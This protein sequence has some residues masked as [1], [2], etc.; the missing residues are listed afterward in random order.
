MRLRTQLLLLA[1]ATLVLP[2]AGWQIVRGLEERL[3]DG[4]AESLHDSARVL[5][6]ALAAT[7]EDAPP[8]GP[9]WFVHAADAPI[10]LDGHADEWRVD[11]A[12]AQAF[13]AGEAPPLQVVMSRSGGALHLLARMRDDSPVRRDATG[14]AAGDGDALRLLIDDGTRIHALRL[15]S[16]TD[17][18][19]L[20]APESGSDVAP[21][22]LQAA[23]RTFAGGWQLEL[24]FAPGFTPRRLGLQ[25]LDVDR[26]GATLR[27]GSEP[28]R[29]GGLWPLVQSSEPL[30]R[31]LQ[32]IVPQGMRARLLHPDGWVLAQAGALSPPQPPERGVWQRSLRA[33]LPTPDAQPAA[34][35]DDVRVPPSM[36]A[37]AAAGDDGTAV[38]ARTPPPWQHADGTLQLRLTALAPLPGSGPPPL[39]LAL[40]RRS[41]AALVAQQALAGLLGWTLLAMVLVAAVLFAYASWLGHR[42]RR[43][44]RAV[45][46]AMARDRNAP[47]AFVASAA[48][49]ELGD[50]SRRFARLLE[51][52]GGYAEYLRT[53]ASKLSH[54]LHTPLAVVR[55]SLENLESQAL[56]ETARPYLLR[57]RD[58]SQRLAAIIR[59]MSEA[60]RV[61]RAIA[62]AEP[63]HVDIA[64]VVGGCAEG[65]RE[66][67]SPRR[68]DVS[69]P[70]Q[71]VWMQAA[72]E[73]LAQALDKLV[74][75][76]AGFCPPHG[77][78][79][80]A[81]SARPD[82]AELVVANSGAPLPAG[83]PARLFESLV[84]VR[85]AG[86][87]GDGTP[88][89]GLG[90]HIVRLIVELHRG[91][92]H[93]HDLPDG[94]GV[95]FR[96]A[97]RGMPAAAAARVDSGR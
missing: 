53:L 88:H 59:A 77:W 67:L 12:V 54:E 57:A 46:Q 90:L 16:A 34:A 26:S 18:A 55:G 95:A 17:G 24:R 50:L 1:A 92:V 37:G 96:I 11:P 8:T 69:L 30:S 48:G 66:L 86:V 23:A 91:A 25:A 85:S 63:E 52:I 21:P 74:E 62:A 47:N 33:L 28:D 31:R 5:A 45:D 60:T 10:T 51:E 49:D 27:H 75:N 61:E 71:P 38:G 94:Q 32:A 3:R 36:L 40:E 93:A 68:L 41:D 73:L 15:A 58:G 42:V 82:G 97:L 35:R 56:P 84:S 44:G 72:P 79:R 78:V 70:P 43:L 6:G 64:A 80:I 29:L 14:P 22:R 9:V 39:L 4:Q 89:L 13:G 65:Y 87:R 7:L 20:P 2:W 81:L 83:A 19:L 76:A